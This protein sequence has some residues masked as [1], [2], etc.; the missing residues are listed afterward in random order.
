MCIINTDNIR[1]YNKH[2][3]PLTVSTRTSCRPPVLHGKTLHSQPLGTEAIGRVAQA[4]SSGGQLREEAGARRSRSWHQ[5]G[6]SPSRLP[7][8]CGHPRG[9]REGLSPGRFVVLEPHRRESG[10]KEAHPPTAGI[11]HL[12]REPGYCLTYKHD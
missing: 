11:I 1:V 4:G 6:T 5:Q 10:E 7:T 12:K 2:G 9:K 8:G 3:H